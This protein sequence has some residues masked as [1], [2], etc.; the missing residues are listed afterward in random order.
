MKLLAHALSLAVK[1]IQASFDFYQKLGFEPLGFG[2]IEEKWI[3]LSNGYMKIGLFQDMFP[4]NIMTFNP[5]DGRAVHK[6]LKEK[7]VEFDVVSESLTEEESGPCHFIFRDPD[8]NTIM[9][10]QLQDGI[11]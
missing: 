9:F 2:S 7:G 5:E 6:D 8:G 4:S 11:L 10:D 1:D 3:I